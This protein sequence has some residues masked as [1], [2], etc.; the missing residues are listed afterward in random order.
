MRDA[1]SAYFHRSV[2][3]RVSRTHIDCITG[4][5]NILYEGNT[6]PNVFVDHYMNFLGVEGIV[7]PLN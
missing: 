6:V 1:N 2:K 5:E 4:H 3:A 7:S